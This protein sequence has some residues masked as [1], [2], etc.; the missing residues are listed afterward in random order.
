MRGPS[1]GCA[2]FAVSNTPASVRL[3]AD[4]L[5]SPTDP[6][7][8]LF[9]RRL[10]PEEPHAGLVFLHGS[11][12][13]SEYYLAWGLTL[14]QQGL[15]VWL[16]DLRGHGHSGGVRGTVER[17]GAY[18]RDLAAVAEAFGSAWPT[19]PLL[20]GGESFGGLVAFLAAAE[21]VVRP[22]GVV[23][24][25]PAFALKAALTPRQRWLIAQAARW[26]P[27]LRPIRPMGIA[28][29]AQWPGLPQLVDTDPLVN[30][31]YTVR[32]LAE[33][34]A[35]QQAAHEAAGR[36]ACPLLVLIAG[37]DRVVDNAATVSVANAVTV[38]VRLR[39]FPDAWHSLTADVP[40][41]LAGEVLAFAA[42][43]ERA[44]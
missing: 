23:L 11:L 17:Y 3:S 31:R 44:L 26:L 20:V 7:L 29:V 6:G 27:T 35:A 28:G 1:P 38:P 39:E 41:E 16:P 9:V 30:R 43:C 25:S 5:A 15:A 18:A 19:L 37:Q 10:E 13:H 12:V 21:D 40:S 8:Q 42:W 36:L 22:R 4:F 34:L 24:S 14:A 33:L 2:G 32:F